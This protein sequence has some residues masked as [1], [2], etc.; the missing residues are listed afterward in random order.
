MDFAT[1][2]SELADIK[3]SL[4]AKCS[5]M[6]GKAPSSVPHPIRPEL[7]DYQ[8][9]RPTTEP[10]PDAPS[11]IVEMVNAQMEARLRPLRVAYSQILDRVKSLERTD[12]R[13]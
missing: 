11:E 7:I 9:P 6:A 1:D 2:P 10:S 3:E 8:P 12:V 4:L 13:R 5:A